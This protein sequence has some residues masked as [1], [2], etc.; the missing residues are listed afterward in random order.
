MTSRMQSRKRSRDPDAD[1][2]TVECARRPRRK[3]PL[4]EATVACAAAMFRASL[5]SPG[6]L[7]DRGCEAPALT[8][9]LSALVDMAL[10]YVQGGRSE[11]DRREGMLS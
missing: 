1:V 5:A 3:P 8:P 10:L 6:R 11:R 2:A 9:L 7:R 4:R